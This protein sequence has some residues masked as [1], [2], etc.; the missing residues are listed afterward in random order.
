MIEHPPTRPYWLIAI[1]GLLMLHQGIAAMQALTI[2]TAP[3]SLSAPFEFVTRSLWSLGFG[4][5]IVRLWRSPSS[6]GTFG[7]ALVLL[8]VFWL[9]TLGH[10]ALWVRADYERQRWPFLVICCSL[11]ILIASAVYLRRRHGLFMENHDHDD[12]PK[13]QN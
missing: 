12:Q 6:L 8:T 5:M 11:W 9:Y 3:V 2:A 7:G 1:G 4:V 10:A 13:P